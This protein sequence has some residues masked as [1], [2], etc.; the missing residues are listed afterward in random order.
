MTVSR[1]MNTKVFF[2]EIVY[3]VY[4]LTFFICL[5]FSPRRYVEI[6]E[7]IVGKNN[8]MAK[9]DEFLKKINLFSDDETCLGRLHEIRVGHER[10]SSDFTSRSLGLHF[11]LGLDGRDHR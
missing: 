11:R 2:K 3:Q 1:I 8:D 6:N 7:K 5:T 4:P 9:I 10:G